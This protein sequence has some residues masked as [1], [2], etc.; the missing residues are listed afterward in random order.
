MI[1]HI[2]IT[3]TNFDR[4][5]SFYRSAL[6][7]LGCDNFT[8]LSEEITDGVKVGGFGYRRPEFWIEEAGPQSPAIHIAFTAHSR[9]Q[10]DEFFKNAVDAGGQNNGPPGLRPHYHQHYYAA[11][12]LDPDGNNVEAVC[13][14]P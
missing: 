10:V 3:T 6:K 9:T 11:F 2:G 7:P 4:A 14:T 8:P 12:V 13:H 1:D 5:I